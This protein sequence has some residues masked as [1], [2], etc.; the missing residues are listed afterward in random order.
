MKFLRLHISLILI[1][2]LIF[3]SI[4][5]TV[6]EN[7]K[8]NKK[9][10]VLYLFWR[11][12]CPHCEK[13]KEFLYSIKKKYPKLEIR[14]YEVISNLASREL[15]MTMSKSYGINPSGVPVTFVGDKGIVGF[16]EEV[17]RQIEDTIKACLKKVCQ[18]P[19]FYKK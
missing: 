4:N 14:D 18:D 15:L 10:V 16:D 6:A 8:D 3:L 12:G 9:S 17:A 7:K 5:S 19:L 2:S 1:L 11:E 13:E